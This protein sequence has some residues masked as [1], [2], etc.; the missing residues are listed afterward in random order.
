[1]VSTLIIFTASSFVPIFLVSSPAGAPEI[2]LPSVRVPIA[3]NS[4]LSAQ[5]A[6]W[7]GYVVEAPSGK[8]SSV[9]M[10][11]IV[12]SVSCS[13]L[14]VN[15]AV[16]WVGIDGAGSSTVEQTGTASNCEIVGADY[17]AWYEFYPS[18]AVTIPDPVHSGDIM[19]GQVLYQSSSGLY[20]ILLTDNSQHWTYQAAGTVSGSKDSSVEW[21]VERPEICLLTVCS[22]T[23]LAN[24]GTVFSGPKY[25]LLSS[26]Q[27]DIATINGKTGSISSFSSAKG[28]TVYEVSMYSL[29][30]PTYPLA[31][32]STLV[33]GRS[34]SVAWKAAS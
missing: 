23:S 2:I 21:I 17:Y 18:P 5:S 10:S 30:S 26:S 29:N 8:I 25:T 7:A 28:D 15:Y 31:T 24:F 19:S 14:S 13:L 1:M 12:P 20:T 34:F 22:L 27:S 3:S 4:I 16:E 6:N 9:K 32:T 33:K 11:W